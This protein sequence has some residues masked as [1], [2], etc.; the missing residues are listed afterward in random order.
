MNYRWILRPYAPDP[1]VEEVSRSLNDLPKALARALVVRGI[2]SFERA[3][4]FFRP[5]LDTLHDPFSM[6][7]MDLAAARVVEAIERAKQA[8][9]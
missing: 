8:K 2:D 3:R 4:H 7:D 6:A 1:L 5:S 9:G